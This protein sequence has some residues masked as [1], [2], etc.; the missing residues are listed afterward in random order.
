VYGGWSAAADGRGVVS[1]DVHEGGTK[2]HRVG[3]GQTVTVVTGV[4]D[5]PALVP[6]AYAR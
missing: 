3:R 4:P 1:Y 5:R 2:I 6:D